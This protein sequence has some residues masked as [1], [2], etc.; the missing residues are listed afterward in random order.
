MKKIAVALVVVAACIL[1]SS[2]THKSCPAYAQTDQEQI[3]DL[4]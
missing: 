1:V 3:E 4:G 2:C